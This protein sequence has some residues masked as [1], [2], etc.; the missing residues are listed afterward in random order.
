VASFMKYLIDVFNL[1]AVLMFALRF[2]K[3]WSV[4]KW[5]AKVLKESGAQITKYLMTIL[6]LSYGDA[7][8][9]IDLRWASNLQNISCRI[10][11]LSDIVF[12]K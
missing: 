5:R 3:V 4:Q 8:V 7:K 11:R 1:M 6:R 2:D 10:V 12:I 9:M